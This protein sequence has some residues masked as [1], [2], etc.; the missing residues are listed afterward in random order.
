MV[1]MVK[2][3]GGG[4]LA[5]KTSGF[6]FGITSAVPATLESYNRNQNLGFVFYP[7]LNVFWYDQPVFSPR[8][9]PFFQPCSDLFTKVNNHLYQ[10][11]AFEYIVH[12]QMYIFVIEI[13]LNINLF[14][15]FRTVI[16]NQGC[17]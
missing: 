9:C 16:L 5:S 7:L 13:Y 17:S 14:Q 12:N 4:D 15:M 2:R 3:S 8:L 6:A 11:P 10:Y 1:E